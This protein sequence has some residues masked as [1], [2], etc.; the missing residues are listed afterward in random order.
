M[1]AGY[2]TKLSYREDLGGQLG[3]PELH[4]STEDISTKAALLAE[5]LS[6]SSNVVAFTGAGIS[7]ACGIPDFRGPSGIWTLQRAHKPIP[8]FKVSFGVA[9]PS[10]THQASSKRCV[11]CKRE[12]IRD[13]EME[14]VGF[15]FTGRRCIADGCNGR[16]K[17]QVL[18]W[19]DALPVDELTA[20]E[21]AAAKAD[22]AICLG[23]SLQITPACNIPLK[24]TKAGGKLV[25]INLQKTPKDSKADLVIHAKC[26]E[27]MQ[28]VMA[29]LRIPL[30]AYTRQDAVCVSHTVKKAKSIHEDT[31]SF[32]CTIHVQSV[33]GPKCPLPLVQQ[34]DLSF[35]DGVL[36]P[37]SIRKQPFVVTRSVSGARTTHV[38][39][40]LQLTDAID[41]AHR[42]QCF[43]HDMTTSAAQCQAASSPQTY[44]F[45]TQNV[46]YSPC[47]SKSESSLDE[48]NCQPPVKRHKST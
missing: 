31:P 12:Y 13:F 14:T 48:Q 7:T 34:V 24:T 38:H 4:D 2:A 5:W 46:L 18:D 45:T 35:Q 32:S 28:Q 39:V 43:T 42:I 17:D 8:E 9:K 6:Q 26:D 10:L 19:E 21:K 15:K 36:R 47:M 33:H 41:D 1:S 23:T 20:S 22:L 40:Q 44:T 27:I 16:L 37:A 3:D 30:P 11:K 25:I 29:Q